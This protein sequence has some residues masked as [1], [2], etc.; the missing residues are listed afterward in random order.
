MASLS[1][2]YTFYLMDKFHL[3]LES[4]QLYLFAF[5][6]AVAAGT[7]LGGATR[8]SHRSQAGDPGSPSSASLP[9]PCCC[10]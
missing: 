10:P 9:S 6:F 1:S 8:R 3:S 5:L 2:Y 7:V 4:A